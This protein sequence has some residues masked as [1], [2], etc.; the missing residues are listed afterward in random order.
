MSLSERLKALHDLY[1]RGLLTDAE[2]TL[3]KAREIEA[4]G[5]VPDDAPAPLVP[6]PPVPPP[7]PVPPAAPPM[8]NP[9]VPGVGLALGA[10]SIANGGL[11]G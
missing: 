4:A 5:P 1:L 9:V 10:A 8:L 3:A 6:V 2:F 7:P 11:T